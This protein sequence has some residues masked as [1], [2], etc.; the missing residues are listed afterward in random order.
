[1][2][3]GHTCK[4]FILVGQRWLLLS[5]ITQAFKA[6]QA[7]LLFNVDTT[8]SGMLQ[9]LDLPDLMI[10]V[11]GLRN[12]LRG[13]EG[14]P[15]H[16]HSKLSKAL[17]GVKVMALFSH[18]LLGCLLHACSWTWLC[19]KAYKDMLPRIHN[20]HCP[21]IIVHHVPIIVHHVPVIIHHVPR[22]S[23]KEDLILF[24]KP[25]SLW[26]P[27][28]LISWR[29]WTMPRERWWR[30]LLTLLLLEGGSL[31]T[32]QTTEGSFL[33]LQPMKVAPWS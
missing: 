12:G 8:H 23:L 5:Y 14:L 3:G 26:L 2:C 18:T 17:R 1:M 21:A 4:C 25:Y 19:F 28:A 32:S 31:Q 20:L 10:R 9:A 11:L 22:W 16:I 13:L 33:E 7:G 27:R 29:S 24:V 6:C 15:P 30:L